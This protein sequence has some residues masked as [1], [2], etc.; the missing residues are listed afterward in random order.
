MQLNRRMILPGLAAAGF[1]G[2]FTQ[3]VYVPSLVQIAQQ[4]GVG[5]VLVNLTISLFVGILAVSGFFIGPLTDRY[6]R[7]RL[8]LPGLGLFILGSLLC[9]FAPGYWWFLVG[10]AV[11]AL[12]VS[13]SLIVAAT[14]IAD[15]YAPNERGAALSIYQLMAYLGPVMGPVAGGLIAEYQSW[16]WAFALLAGA[17]GV[18]LLYNAWVLPETLP[19]ETVPTPLSRR[20]LADAFAHRAASAIMLIAFSQ[21]YGYYSFLVFLPQLLDKH[22]ELSAAARG[23]AFVPLTAGLLLGSLAA[24]FLSGRVADARLI[25]LAA[26]LVACDVLA[27]WYLLLAGQL[28]FP[29]L[30]LLMLLYGATL[31]ISLPAQTAMLVNLFTQSRATVV[32]VFNSVR[33]FGAAAGPLLGGAIAYCVGLP[34]AFLA[35][36]LLLLGAAWVG[37]R[38]LRAR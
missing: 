36:G 31:G 18:V 33:F 6:G 27:L 4:F 16:Q 15:L 12:G 3:T 32:G 37:K 5:T 26:Y 13:I 21:F 11:Q 17:G 14:V 25:T 8:L 19:V 38:Q 24:R 22:F 20:A 35:L 10:R 30:P 29:L 2:P 23:F 28:S 1:I 7:R 9:L 34:Q